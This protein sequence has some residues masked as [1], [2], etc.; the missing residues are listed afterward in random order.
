M[1]RLKTLTLTPT[2]ADRN[3]ISTTE[4]LLAARLDYLINGVLSTGFDRNGI[5][6]AQAGASG[7]ALTINGAI[8]S[9]FFDRGGVYLTLFSAASDN[10]GDTLVDGVA[11]VCDGLVW[12]VEHPLITLGTAGAVA[13]A[14]VAAPYAL[15]FVAARL[16]R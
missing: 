11:K 1:S 15:P 14:V 2:A 12:L 6:E 8:G 5:C 13:G 7:V 4:T 3:G 10:T 9:D 16:G